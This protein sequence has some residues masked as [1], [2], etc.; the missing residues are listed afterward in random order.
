MA[1][2]LK[3]MNIE[4]VPINFL[5]PV[6]G[7]PLGDSKLLSP[8]EALKIIAIYRLI[9]PGSEIRVCGG[10]PQTLRELNSYIFFAGADGLLIGNY[11][12]TQGK[13]PEED[14][15]MINDMGLEI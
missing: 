6:S 9:L 15:Q 5:T 14:L 2:A 4:S 13:R 10:R 7:T 1:F 8:L 3:E 11:L 12:T